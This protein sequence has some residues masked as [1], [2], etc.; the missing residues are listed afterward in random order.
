MNWVHKGHPPGALEAR[1]HCVDCV[2]WPSPLASAGPC[3]A[4]LSL[5]GGN[6]SFISK[7]LGNDPDGQGDLCSLITC[8]HCGVYTDSPHSWQ[9][10]H[11]GATRPGRI[12]VPASAGTSSGL[13][14]SQQVGGRPRERPE[15]LGRPGHAPAWPPSC[16]LPSPPRESCFHG[17]TLLIPAD[18]AAPWPHRV[19]GSVD[20]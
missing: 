19:R 13:V 6:G 18:P 5:K 9:P 15:P 17:M 14:N 4:I 10:S 20:A 8:S 3:P 11:S 1:E 2:S 16:S 7:A 12:P